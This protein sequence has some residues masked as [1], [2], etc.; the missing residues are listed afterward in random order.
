[1]WSICAREVDH[2]YYVQRMTGVQKFLRIVN[3]VTCG[4]EVDEALQVKCVGN[5]RARVNHVHLRRNLLPVV[6]LSE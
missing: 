5:R 1:M 6:L 2:A 3:L 4:V